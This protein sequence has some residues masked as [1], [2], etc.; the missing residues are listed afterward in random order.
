V[1]A[2]HT[3][4]AERTE[5][6]PRRR[7]EPSAVHPRRRAEPSAVHP[8]RRAEPSAV[9]PRRRAEPSAVH[10]RTGRPARPSVGSGSGTCLVCVGSA[11]FGSTGKQVLFTPINT[12]QITTLPP[13][14]RPRRVHTTF[15]CAL[16]N[17][18]ALSL[19]APPQN[20]TRALPM[21]TTV[22]LV[23]TGLRE[24]L[25]KGADRST[26]CFMAHCWSA[27]SPSASQAPIAQFRETLPARR[28]PVQLSTRPSR[29]ILYQL[30]HSKSSGVPRARD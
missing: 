6:H 8:R 22:T 16:E 30:S 1:A 19:P 5:V 14:R 11:R 9:L 12:V 21:I 24:A 25:L 2:E 15:L 27:V 26:V 28:R 18:P 7:A 29:N 4:A 10:L 13:T 3:E 20:A 17:P 23:S